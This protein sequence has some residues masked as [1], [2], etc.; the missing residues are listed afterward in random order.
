M[1]FNLATNGKTK[2]KV[3]RNISG[4]TICQTTVQN[5][6]ISNTCKYYTIDSSPNQAWNLGLSKI[7]TN[8]PL[9]QY[10]GDSSLIRTFLC[11]TTS[12]ETLL[13]VIVLPELQNEK[14]FLL[15]YHLT[16]TQVV[17]IF[18]ANGAS[19]KLSNL[20]ESA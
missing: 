1:G 9:A 11:L 7:P 20:K 17:Q 10:I 18:S 5:N 4:K 3:V 19:N 8:V 14:R 6:Q 15:V 16:E 13:F 2:K 12:F